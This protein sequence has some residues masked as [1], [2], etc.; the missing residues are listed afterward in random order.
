MNIS[1]EIVEQ[2]FATLVRRLTVF[3]CGIPSIIHKISPN[4]TQFLTEFNL[5]SLQAVPLK[6]NR[7][8]APS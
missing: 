4:L 7:L 1:N 3:V 8:C 6:P 5:N 2:E